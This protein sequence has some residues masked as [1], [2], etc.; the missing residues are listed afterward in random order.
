MCLVDKRCLALTTKAHQ[1]EEKERM[2]S[3]ML[4]YPTPFATE[5]L[6][7]E[8]LTKQMEMMRNIASKGQIVSIDRQS[9]IMQFVFNKLT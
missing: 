7:G 9:I 3:A 5:A 1:S 6:V 4:K 8:T 2:A